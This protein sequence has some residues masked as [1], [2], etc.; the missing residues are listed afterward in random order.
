MRKP[1]LE[2]KTYQHCAL[3]GTAWFTGLFLKTSV[4]AVVLMLSAC[5]TSVQ[6][7]DTTYYLFD[8]NPVSYPQKVNTSNGLLMIDVVALPDYLKTNQL[9]MKE[10]ENRIVKAN[11]HSWADD[12]D[13]SIQ[14]AII[15]DLNVALSET[16]VVDFCNSC[17]KVRITVEHFYPTQAGDVLLSGYYQ[18]DHA[19]NE[20]QVRYFHFTSELKG[21]GY[22]SAVTQM[23]SLVADF[24]ASLVAYLN[25]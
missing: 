8:S 22:A 19:Q 24:S 23:R 2:A 12:L 15:N 18:I 21:D 3:N 1:T 11:Y 14:R 6:A 17:Q 13:E 20:G 9:V 4:C 7:P 5:T 16:S 10:G 25:R